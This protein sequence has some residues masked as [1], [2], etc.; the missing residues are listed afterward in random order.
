MLGVQWGACPQGTSVAVGAR[1]LAVTGAR[2]QERLAGGLAVPANPDPD[3]PLPCEHKEG[4]GVY[5]QPRHAAKCSAG[6]E[7]LCIASTD[8][9]L[10]VCPLCKPRLGERNEGLCGPG[11]MDV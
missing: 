10:R 2:C 7:R 11:G 4:S 3:L 1:A 8:G 6:H 5:K 9:D